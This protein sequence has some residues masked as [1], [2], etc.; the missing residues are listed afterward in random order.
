MGLSK[1]VVSQPEQSVPAARKTEAPE[2]VPNNNKLAAIDVDR[3]VIG[4]RSPE[5]ADGRLPHHHGASESVDLE[6]IDAGNYTKLFRDFA[7]Q[8]AALNKN[9]ELVSSGHM[10]PRPWLEAFRK[11]FVVA[12]EAWNV[13]AQAPKL[14]SKKPSKPQFGVFGYGSLMKPAELADD[15][16]GEIS[17]HYAITDCSAEYLQDNQRLRFYLKRHLGYAGITRGINHL[18]SKGVNAAFEVGVAAVQA[19]S[20][21]SEYA[22]DPALELNGV[23]L[24]NYSEEHFKKILQREFAYFL[25]PGPPVKSADAAGGHT[26]FSLL[27]WPR[28]RSLIDSGYRISRRQLDMSSRHVFKKKLEKLSLAPSD[29]LLGLRPEDVV[30]LLDETPVLSGEEMEKRLRALMD[31]GENDCQIK[32]QVTILEKLQQRVATFYSLTRERPVYPDPSY[33]LKEC[34]QYGERGPKVVERFLNTT[35]V[36][37]PTGNDESA[38]KYVRS[39]V[40]HC[41]QNESGMRGDDSPSLNPN[42]ID[43]TDPLY[44][45]LVAMRPTV[46]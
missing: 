3:S 1:R 9:Q 46:S 25:L 11:N 33:V 2:V 34:L 31:L 32:E 10:Y 42:P 8:V 24:T 29:N 43:T 37:S 17:E 39:Q 20:K 19:F 4:A 27:C 36:V 23:F 30:A 21:S 7:F 28:G 45:D 22:Y 35:W 6:Q 38:R 13:Y 12:T 40:P 44:S 41:T 15:V 26:C 18:S 16:N 5:C 14:Q